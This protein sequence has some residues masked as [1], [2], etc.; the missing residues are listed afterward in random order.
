MGNPIADTGI[1]LN[2]GSGPVAVGG[3]VNIDR[4]PNVLLDRMPAIKRALRKMNVIGDG[5]MQPWSRDIV[6]GNI[7]ALEYPDN[8]VAAVYSSHTLE[9]IYF[10]EAEQVIAEAHRVLRPGGVLRLALPDAQAMAREFLSNGAAA[11]ASMEYNRM[12]NTHPL[13]RPSAL[14]RALGM[15]GGHIHLWQP[16]A[17]LLEAMMLKAGFGSVFHRTFREGEC[18]LLEEVETRPNSFFVEATK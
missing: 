7:T 6:R 10:A 12:L 15:A 1:C 3:W 16:T 5:H 18:P 17:P 11:D 2:L 4:S 8:S 13:H 14:Q 9:H